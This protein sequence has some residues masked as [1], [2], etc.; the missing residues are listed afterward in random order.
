MYLKF[1][2]K[3]LIHRN[4][5]FEKYIKT[6]KMYTKRESSL[7]EWWKTM[8]RLSNKSKTIDII[9]ANGYQW[10]QCEKKCISR[11]IIVSEKSG[12][13]LYQ[14]GH[15]VLSLTIDEAIPIIYAA[16]WSKNRRPL[17]TTEFNNCITP[18]QRIHG[19]R[20]AYTYSTIKK[21][22]QAGHNVQYLWHLTKP[23]PSILWGSFSNLLFLL[24]SLFTEWK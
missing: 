4:Y 18:L 11:K 19:Q 15:N 8:K 9:Y 1:V 21:L 2:Y 6:F 12:S 3:K 24:L 10:I 5:K 22:Y 23:Y 7:C 17:R 13:K 14:A 16:I 20:S